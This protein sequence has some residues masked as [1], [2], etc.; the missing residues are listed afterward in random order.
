[1]DSSLHTTAQFVMDSLGVGVYR[2]ICDN[3][4]EG[5]NFLTEDYVRR[6]SQAST[7]YSPKSHVADYCGADTPAHIMEMEENMHMMADT[8]KKLRGGVRKSRR[9]KK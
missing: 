3:G 7:L 9:I 8:G 6:L 5:G 2:D 4:I 1:M